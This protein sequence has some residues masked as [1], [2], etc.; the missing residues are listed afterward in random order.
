MGYTNPFRRF[1]FR[2]DLYKRIKATLADYERRLRKNEV[3]DLAR[4]FQGEDPRT[5]FDVG[6]NVGFLSWQ[7]LKVFRNAAIYAFEPDPVPFGTLQATHGA[8][9]RVRVFRIAAADKEGE[10]AFR[11][12]GVSCNSSLCDMAGGSSKDGGQTIKVKATTLDRF[13]AEESITHID[14]LKTDTE[15]AD[16]LVLN[17]AK[18]ILGQ[19][20]IEVAMAE[21]LFVP[22]YKGQA[23]FDEIARFLRAYDFR[24]FNVYIGGETPRGQARYGNAIFVGKRLQQKLEGCD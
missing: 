13:C 4:L 5:V 21:V 12:R 8:N 15:G 14:L 17:G 22:I 10:V 20:G 11:Q 19:G 1:I 18:G 3:S 9:P 24:V 23:T 7:F 16:L 6:A 2:K